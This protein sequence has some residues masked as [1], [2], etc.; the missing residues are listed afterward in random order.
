MT[1]KKTCTACTAAVEAYQ[2]LRGTDK[3]GLAVKF[4]RHRFSKKKLCLG[5][6]LTLCTLGAWAILGVTELDVFSVRALARHTF[7]LI[8][9]VPYSLFCILSFVALGPPTKAVHRCKRSHFGKTGVLTEVA[10]AAVQLAAHS[11]IQ[12][13]GCQLQ[14]WPPHT[15]GG[16]RGELAGCTLQAGCRL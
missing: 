1:S 14:S 11:L 9:T 13:A 5:L 7:S 2:K 6:T 16:G 3:A 4:A 8:R 15:A 10:A 12:I